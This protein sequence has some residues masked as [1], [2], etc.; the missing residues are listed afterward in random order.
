MPGWK[1][2]EEDNCLGPQI[3]ESFRDPQILVSMHIYWVM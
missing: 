3:F 2:D 1:Y